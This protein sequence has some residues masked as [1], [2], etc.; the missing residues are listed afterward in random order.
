MSVPRTAQALLLAIA[1]VA[2]ACTGGDVAGSPRQPAEAVTITLLTHDSFDVSETVVRQFERERGVEL[3]IVPA[4]DAGQLVNRAILTAGN[5]EGDVLFGVDDSLMPAAIE[6]GVFE[7]YESREL[8]RVDDAFELDPTHSVTPIARGDVCLNVD[9][10]WF[11]GRGLEPPD[12]F[13]DLTGPVYRG[14]TVVENPASS[15]PGLAFLLATIARFGEPAWETFWRDLRANDVLVVEGWEQAYYGEFSGAGGGA[16][17][18][19]IVVSYATSPVAEVVFAEEPLERAPTAAVTESCYRQV[20]FAGVLAGTEHPVEAR[21]VVD[22]LLSKPF[23]EDVPLRMFVFPVVDDA[24]LPDAF[25]RW[26][27]EPASPLAIAPEQVEAGRE[28][29]VRRWTDLMFG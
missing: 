23:Q 7:P 1:L 16:G 18:R 17:E 19:P 13:A 20:E 4:G 26:A 27:E 9:L 14:L 28:D 10:T 2:V 21:S 24:E 29:W 3:R 25:V 8:V 6:A 11:L 12:D 15:T 22:F 5:P